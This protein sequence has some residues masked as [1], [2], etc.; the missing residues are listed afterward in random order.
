MLVSVL[1][2]SAGWGQDLEPRSYSA[3]PVGTSFAGVGF[4]RS[5]GDISFDPTVPITNAS[6]TLYSP[7]LGLGQTFGVL[8]RQALFTVS[9]PYAWGNASGDVGNGEQNIYRSGLADVKARFSINLRGSPALTPREFAKRTHR[10][11]IVGTSLTFTA[12][13]GQYSGEKLI[14]LGTNRWS[15]KPE[16]GVSYP[17]KK[18]DLDLYAGAWFFME[19]GNFYPGQV[20][21][22]QDPLTAIQAH[23]S[24]TV[25]RSLWMAFD[26][27]W[28][29]GGAGIVGNGPPT[30]RQSN[31]RAGVTVSLPLA[32]G[33]SIKF[34][35]SSGVTGNVGAKFT[36]IGIGWQYVWFNR[37]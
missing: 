13:T 36:T 5:S 32:K 30:Q 8:G 4:G 28:Y 17:V 26:A 2:A 29:G 14:N 7:A 23:V 9:L 34:A 16:V 37:R 20:T 6:A 24:Y 35:Y 1:L 3:S 25:R 15:F 11:F 21:R 18:L 33:Q 22:S 12:P 27:T 19:N 10:S 31:S